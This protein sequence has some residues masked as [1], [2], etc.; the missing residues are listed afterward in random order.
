MR[1]ELT[2]VEAPLSANSTI[3]ALI[4]KEGTLN[5]SICKGETIKSGTQIRPRKVRVLLTEEENR[6][7]THLVFYIEPF[8]SGENKMSDCQRKVLRPK[9]LLISKH[10]TGKEVDK[11]DKMLPDEIQELVNTDKIKKNY[12]L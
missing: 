11:N 2:K 1:E 6:S 4:T 10:P 12:V 9:L 5:L 8:F 3:Y 7:I